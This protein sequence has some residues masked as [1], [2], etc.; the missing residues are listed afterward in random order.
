MDANKTA[1]ERC[2][3][4]PVDDKV[5]DVALGWHAPTFATSTTKYPMG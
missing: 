1:P 3:E 2:V 4:T 5:I